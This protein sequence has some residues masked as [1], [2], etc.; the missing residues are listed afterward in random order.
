MHVQFSAG[1]DLLTRAYPDLSP[2]LKKCAAYILEHPSEVAT[3]SMRQV[4]ARAS[5]PP[6]TMTRLARALDLGTYNEL[7]A[8]YRDSINTGY[9]A[10]TGQLQADVGETSLDPML[11]AFRQAALNNLNTLFDNIDRTAIDRAI[12]ALTVARNVLVIGMHSSYSFA[13]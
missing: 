13:N 4:A 2:Q 6:S 9:P 8:L 5:V 10:K 11:D 12:Q 1:T 7:R 3:L